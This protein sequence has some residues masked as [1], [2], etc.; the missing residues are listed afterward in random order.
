MLANHLVGRTEELGSLDRVL[1]ELDQG[2]ATAVRLLG[3]A[4]IGKTRLLGELVARRAAR[5]PSSSRCSSELER[6]NL[7]FSVFV[8]ALDEYVESLEAKWLAVLDDDVSRARACLP[9]AVGACGR[10]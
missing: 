10:P 2:R 7:P 5:P 4:G 8:D 9:I 3:E 6:R 1:I